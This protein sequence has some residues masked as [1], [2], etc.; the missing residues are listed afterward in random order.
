MSEASGWEVDIETNVVRDIVQTGSHGRL[1][2]WR[3]NILCKAQ[4]R[5][6]SFGTTIQR[7]S[8]AECPA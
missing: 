6:I 8:A 2:M 7:N 1:S 5:V 4:A 3:R